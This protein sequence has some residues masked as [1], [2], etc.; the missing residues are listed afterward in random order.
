MK[1]SLGYNHD[2]RMLD[3]LEKY[4][5]NIE[6]LYFP[7][8]RK[9]T[10]SGRHVAQQE[11]YID[12]IPLIIGKCEFL[13]IKTQLLLNATCV[14]SRGL[15]KELFLSVLDYLKQLQEIGLKCIVTANPIYIPELRKEFNDIELES[16]INCYVKTVEHALYLKELGIDVITIDRDI[17]RDIPLIKEIKKATGLKIRILLNEGCLRNCPFR[18]AHFNYI[19]HADG[20]PEVDMISD[21]FF[22]K[23]CVNLFKENPA[24][25]FRIPFIPPDALD[26]YTPFADYFKLATRDSTTFHIEFKLKAYIDRTYDGNLLDLLASACIHPYYK[27]IDY[28]KLKSSNYFERMLSCGD[29]CSECDYCRDLAEESVVT[30]SYF[31]DESDPNRMGEKQKAEKVYKDLL[32]TADESSKAI[33]Y[34]ELTRVLTGLNRFEEAMDAA[35]KAKELRPEDVETLIRIGEIFEKQ[36]RY[37]DAMNKYRKAKMTTSA[38][39]DKKNRIPFCLYKNGDYEQ[40]IQTVAPLKDIGKVS[41]KMSFLVGMCYFEKGDYRMALEELLRAESIDNKNP[42]INLQLAKCYKELGDLEMTRQE[43]EKG[44]GRLQAFLGINSE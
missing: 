39:T 18:Q 27:Y 21:K 36:K 24:I 37:D 10:G 43:M 25:I 20:P 40:A 8:P 33:I 7:V 35:E 32:K 34:M 5:E 19:A 26:H 9:F 42:R 22:E 6:A 13:G 41:G 11:R 12:E 44:A 2:I 31:L 30:D 23:W 28:Q 14:G 3:L 38:N 1:F 17:N 29:G 4:S 16:S 15:E